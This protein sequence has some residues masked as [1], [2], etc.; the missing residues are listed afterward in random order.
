LKEEVAMATKK[1]GSSEKTLDRKPAPGSPV[2]QRLRKHGY[3]G[4]PLRKAGPGVHFGRGFGGVEPL[5]GGENALPRAGMF[6]EEST[7]SAS[8]EPDSLPK[9]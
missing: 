3:Q 6:S 1:S 5:G 2:S 9:R 4:Y 7:K 8:E